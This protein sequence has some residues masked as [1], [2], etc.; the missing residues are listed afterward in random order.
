MLLKRFCSSCLS[1][2]GMSAQ[3][4]N[5]LVVL[6]M[7]WSAPWILFKVLLPQ[8]VLFGSNLSHTWSQP[9]GSQCYRLEKMQVCRSS[10]LW[11]DCKKWRSTVVWKGVCLLADPEEILCLSVYLYYAGCLC[12]L[13]G[14]PLYESCSNKV[15]KMLYKKVHKAEEVKDLDFYAFSYYYDRAAEVGLIGR[16]APVLISF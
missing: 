9:E 7:E 8:M 11:R 12:I 3:S 13:S 1:R 4:V 10:S 6:Q 2:C 5:L 16:F 15:A 14:E